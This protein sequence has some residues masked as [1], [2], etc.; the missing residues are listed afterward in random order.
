[1]QSYPFAVGE[2]PQRI[3]DWD[4][5]GKNLDFL[6]GVDPEYFIHVAQVNASLAESGRTNSAALAIRLGYSHA[7]ES[8]M[9][10]AAATFQAPECPIGWMLR[11]TN[12]DLRKVIGRINNGAIKYSRLASPPTWLGLAQTVVAGLSASDEAKAN[13]S[14]GFGGLWSRF[15]HDFLDETQESEYNNLKH[16]L[17]ATRGGFAL[18]IGLEPSYGVSP[19]PDEMQLLGGSDYGSSFFVVEKPVGG[20]ID[21]RPRH[22]SRNWHPENLSQGM[23]L[24]ALSLGNLVSY[25]LARGGE[26]VSKLKFEWPADESILD[27]PWKYNLGVTTSNFDTVVEAEHIEPS[28]KQSVLTDIEAAIAKAAIPAPPDI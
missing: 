18:K 6:R 22:F 15:A 27:S 3:W 1:M 20:K 14:T 21:F 25:L 10:F 28:T 19:P 24:L 5:R 23:R 9:A 12:D 4:L 16:G 8:F 26:D 2:R 17:R 7:L 11:Y 13:L